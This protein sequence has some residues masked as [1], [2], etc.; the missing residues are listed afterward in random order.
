M[1]TPTSNKFV[2][3]T[4]VNPALNSTLDQAHVMQNLL[5]ASGKSSDPCIYA[6]GTNLMY[7]ETDS[8][9]NDDLPTWVNL[10]GPSLEDQHLPQDLPVYLQIYVAEHGQNFCDVASLWKQLSVYMPK[11]V[12]QIYPV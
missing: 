8:Q 1:A 5:K 7:P 3:I 2:K 6:N 10:G 9:N 4:A 12:D 11:L